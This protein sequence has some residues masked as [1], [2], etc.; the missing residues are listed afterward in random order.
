MVKIVKANWETWS[1][2][3]AVDRFGMLSGTVMGRFTVKPILCRV[4]NK[5]KKKRREERRTGPG[6]IYWGFLFFLG[7]WSNGFCKLGTDCLWRQIRKVP[8]GQN[9]RLWLCSASALFWVFSWVAYLERCKFLSIFIF[10]FMRM[11]PREWCL[12]F[13]LGWRHKYKKPRSA[14]MLLHLGFLSPSDMSLVV[15]MLR[16]THTT[17]R[18]ILVWLT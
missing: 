17:L 9:R 12:L 13:I 4:K 18:Q 5:N 3:F 10:I 15:G 16:R 6:T 11:R 7:F 14:Q 1:Q 8:Q 2:N